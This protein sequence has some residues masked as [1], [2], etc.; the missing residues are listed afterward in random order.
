VQDYGLF[1]TYFTCGSGGGSDVNADD[2]VRHIQIDRGLYNIYCK[3]IDRQSPGHQER[4]IS[5][6]QHAVTS[7]GFSIYPQLY[8]YSIYMIGVVKLD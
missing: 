6:F 2:E 8:Y 3:C 5:V 1:S 7:E 4:C